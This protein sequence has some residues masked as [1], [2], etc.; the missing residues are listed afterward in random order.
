LLR[1]LN[2]T[3]DVSTNRIDTYTAGMSQDLFKAPSV[4]SFFSPQFRTEGGILG[5]EFQ[6]YSTQTVANRANAV[7]TIL[8]GHLD[9]TTTVDLTPFVNQAG[10]TSGLLNYIAS[11]F[12]HGS[13]SSA[14]TQ[15]ATSAMNA[16]S[17]PLAKV[18]AALYVVLTSGEYNVVR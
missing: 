14:L 4:F 9:T 18:Q 5:P 11:V 3:I 12:L 7:N 13:I 10:S 8:Y 2:A 16:Q 15:A 6:I 17:T 1:G